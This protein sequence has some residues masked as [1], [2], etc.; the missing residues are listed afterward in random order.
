MTS[1]DNAA[2]PSLNTREPS[3]DLTSGISKT[4]MSFSLSE[5]VN[6]VSEN[7]CPILAAHRA[8]EVIAE[9]LPRARMMVKFE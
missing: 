8:G 2:T 1:S 7:A 6:G 3:A 9:K 5:M 4:L